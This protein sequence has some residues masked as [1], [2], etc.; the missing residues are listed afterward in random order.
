MAT[1]LASSVGERRR[2]RAERARPDDG[3]ASVASADANRPG[4]RHDFDPSGT[5]FPQRGRGR[6][7]RG[8]SRVDVVDEG[9]GA[10]HAPNRG[11]RRGDVSAPL[12]P[13]QLALPR[14]TAGPD[15]QRF[16]SEVPARSQ[17]VGEPLG[18][19]VPAAQAPV[20]VAGYEHEAGRARSRQ[21]LDDDLRGPGGEPSQ[22]TFLPGGHDPPHP[23]VVFDRRARVRKREPTTR[24]LRTAPDRPCGGRAAALTAGRLDAPKRGSASGTHLSTGKR[25]DE[26]ALRQQ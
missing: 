15:E 18:G 20:R 13:C 2:T 6:V 10:R 9:H 3:A 21:R 19:V 5:S 4:E 1:L 16:N 26:A 22:P 23:L 25:T 7:G 14:R 12:E 17:A 11:E 8:S 24:T